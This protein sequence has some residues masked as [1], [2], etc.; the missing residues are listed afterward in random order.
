MNK[1]KLFSPMNPQKNIKHYILNIKY[2]I[3]P[4]EFQLNI[5][6]IYFCI[7]TYRDNVYDWTKCILRLASFFHNPCIQTPLI[8]LFTFCH[9]FL[10]RLLSTGHQSNNRLCHVILSSCYN[11]RPPPFFY[12]TTSLISLILV[13]SLFHVNLLLYLFFLI[14]SIAL[15]IGL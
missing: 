9:P 7:I 15:S 11:S 6:H 5:H 10:P 3:V 8:H 12:L 13:C 14:Y 2:Y 1:I 4:A